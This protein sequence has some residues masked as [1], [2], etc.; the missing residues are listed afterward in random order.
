MIKEELSEN[1]GQAEY[2]A[3]QAMDS[4]EGEAM[5]AARDRLQA[6]IDGGL[7]AVDAVVTLGKELPPH[8]V[9]YAASV[10]MLPTGY[11][12]ASELNEGSMMKLTQKQLTG[13]I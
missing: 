3:A 10:V 13:M 11:V 6:L 5:F 4:P 8:L 12:V 1:H 9:E 2:D 7:E